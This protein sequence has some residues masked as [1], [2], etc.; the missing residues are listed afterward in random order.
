MR[1]IAIINQKGG[2][3]KTTSAINLAACFAER[4][5]RTLL[6]DLDPQSHCAAGLAVP[7]AHIDR[8]VADAMLAEEGTKLDPQRF[9]W[10]VAK[11]FDLLPSR[12]KLAA[13]EAARGGL[14]TLADREQ[15]LSV[16]IQALEDAGEQAH[17]ICV[18]DCP[19]S[20]GLLTYNALTA[21]T[22][23]LIPVETAYFSL[24][25]ATKQVSTIRSV[26]R[27]M[28]RTHRTSLVGTLH[29]E[30]SEL[31]GDLLSELRRRFGD[32]VLDA[33]VRVDR[34]LREAA[35]FGRPVIEYAPESTG[36]SDYRALAARVLEAEPTPRSG[37]EPDA[38]DEAVVRVLRQDV[39][40]L[41]RKSLLRG[42]AAAPTAE[43]KPAPRPRPHSPG[44]EVPQHPARVAETARRV[45]D[46]IQRARELTDRTAAGETAV[47]TRHAAGSVRLVEP[48]APPVARN[49]SVQRLFGVRVTGRRALF[50]QPLELGQ[51]ISIAGTF[52]DWAADRH[53]MR[54]NEELGV[55]ELAIDLPQGEYQYRL[56]VDGVWRSDPYNVEQ[57]R[58]EYN[59]MNSTV[60]VA[61]IAV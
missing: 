53:L 61:S 45:D 9:L 6:I 12:T 56:V 18:I 59:E 3:G 2:C 21:A 55:H 35:S 16:A 54:R 52:N 13:L 34:A 7:E 51:R 48:V 58:N 41:S 38:L 8:D 50:V 20:I 1:T 44:D 33:T 40:R 28:G 24:Q 23:V 10:R 60:R 27:R 39:P 57:S 17:D 14:A 49:R 25:G 30:E 46:L 22:E 4:G 47:M 31:A 36:A 11:N 42:E 5:H 37:E 43:P 29:D 19:P 15:R 26:G 32:A